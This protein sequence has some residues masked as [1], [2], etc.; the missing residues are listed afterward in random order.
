MLC[1][2]YIVPYIVVYYRM[3][4]QPSQSQLSRQNYSMWR[5]EQ[6]RIVS[7]RRQLSQVT[8]LTLPRPSTLRSTLPGKFQ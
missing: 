7:L 2:T 5:R 6:G 8:E 4:Y 1:V 3:Y